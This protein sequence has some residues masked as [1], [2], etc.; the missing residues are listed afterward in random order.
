MRA[1]PILM[2]L[3]PALIQSESQQGLPSA[4]SAYRVALPGYH[5][6]FPRDN[7]NHPEFQTEWWYY[8]GNLRS[9]DG[10]QFGFELTFFRRAVRR[11]GSGPPVV[12]SRDRRVILTKRR[13]SS[14]GRDGDSTDWRVDDLYL[15]HLALSDLDARRYLHTERLNRAGPGIAGADLRQSRIWN[16]NWEVRWQGETQDL[17]AVGDRFTLRLSMKSLKPP[18]IHGQNG[19]SQKA[20]APGRSSYYISLTRLATNGTVTLDEKGYE[21]TGLTWMDHEFFSS[22]LDPDQVGWDW[23][24]LQLDDGSELMLYRLRRRDGSTDSYSA[25]TYIDPRGRARHLTAAD[26]ALEPGQS[27]WTSP[28]TRATYPIRWRVQV[29]SLGALLEVTTPLETQEFTSGSRFAPSYWEGAIRAEGRKS[30]RA[31]KAVGYLEMTG[32]DRPLDLSR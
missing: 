20:A 22:E 23:L 17:Q 1:I 13:A 18:V 7:F 32:Y 27:T 16:G 26:Y 2:I 10:H 19:I 5:Y 11:A 21:V 8:T 15:A 24:S 6:E 29:A 9:A 31:V 3:L 14:G 25:G 28:E 30:S 4:T 12:A